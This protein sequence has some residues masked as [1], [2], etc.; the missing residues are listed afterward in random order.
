MYYDVESIRSSDDA[1]I[2]V[3]LMIFFEL[4]GLFHQPFR[5]VP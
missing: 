3:M 4:G 2:T 1:M 5:C